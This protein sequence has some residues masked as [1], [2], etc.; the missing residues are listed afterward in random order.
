MSAPN[1]TV[2][3]EPFESGKVVFSPLAAKTS[4]D[5]P[6]AQLALKLSIKNNEANQVHVNQLKVSFVGPPQVGATTIPLSLDIAAHTTATW[7]FSTENNIILPVPA[8]GTVKIELSC[9]GFN[10]PAS[11]SLPLTAHKSPVPGQSYGFPARASDLRL[12]EYWTG[13]SAKH[14]AAGD[15]S[16]LFAYDMG[17]AGWDATNHQWSCCCPASRATRTR[18]IASGASRFTQSPTAPS[19]SSATIFPPTRIR[20]PTSLRRTL[21]KAIISTFSPETSWSCT[22]TFSPDHSILI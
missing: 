14:G 6:N 11:L 9:N 20:R 15:G 12:G 21:S 1:L 13:V 5:K 19:W 17:V 22:R 3:V 2:G 8:P 4:N 16:Q 18:T 10:T 7:F